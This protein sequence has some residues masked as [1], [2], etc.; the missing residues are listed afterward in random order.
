MLDKVS[1]AKPGLEYNLIN[2]HF[3][4]EFYFD[5]TLTEIYIY[6]ELSQRDI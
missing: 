5:V 3:I 1:L 4:I 6:V 2:I